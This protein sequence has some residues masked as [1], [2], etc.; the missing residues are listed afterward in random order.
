MGHDLQRF[1]EFD[2]SAA[3]PADLFLTKSRASLLEQ[4]TAEVFAGCNM[5]TIRGCRGVGK[6]YLSHHLVSV[7]RAHCHGVICVSGGVHGLAQ[8]Q[9]LV[10]E[11]MSKDRDAAPR[12]VLIV[13]DAK[14]CPAALFTY[15]W[16]LV[17]CR[18][19]GRR[20]IQLVLIGDVGPWSGLNEPG[21]E[22]LREASTSCYILAPFEDDEAAA[23]LRHRFRRAGRRCWRPRDRKAFRDMLS[24]SQGVPAILDTLVSN[25]LVAQTLVRDARLRRKQGPA[26]ARA[27]NRKAGH[28]GWTPNRLAIGFA[29]TIISAIALLANVTAP[30]RANNLQPP[31]PSPVH[32]LSSARL[33]PVER[34][35]NL[36]LAPLPTAVIL[37]RV[38]EPA[39]EPAGPGLVLVAAAGDDIRVL[40]DKVY[41]GVTPPSYPAFLAANR[42]PIKP[43][44]LVIFP[45]PPHGWP[46]P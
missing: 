27:P 38:A 41:R 6:T 42:S 1:Y 12:L 10:G 46:S 11:A 29:S 23:Y 9:G 15:L 19:A 7:F 26:Q 44:G 33:H 17:S 43:G 37:G 2:W 30:P 18:R 3:E 35:A 5:L 4:V 25:T 36:S 20:L 40:Y 13:D 32:L 22:D 8:V 16:S 34:M 24:Q 31:A 28:M 45:E 21:L 39:A 14:A